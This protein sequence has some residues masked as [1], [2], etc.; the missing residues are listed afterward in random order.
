[1]KSSQH[2]TS[3]PVGPML[4]EISGWHQRLRQLH[5]RLR[6]YFA[7]PEVFE[8]TLLYLQA[9]LSDIPRKNGWQIAEQARQAHPYGMQRLLSRA[10]WDQDG[11]RDVLRRLVKDTLLP[12]V[13]APQDE[14][15][16]PVLVLDESGIPKR[17]RHSAG[18][19]PQYCGRTGRVEN[20]QVGVF[21]SYVTSLGHGLID[22]EL[23]LPEDWCADPVRRQATHIP[24]TLTF[25]TKPELAQRMIECAQAAG[26]PIAW[27]V[28]DTVYGHSPQLRSFLQEQGY[29]YALAVPCTEVVCVQTKTGSILLG[30]VA[31][32][33]QQALHTKDWQRL[34]QSLGT[35]GARLFDWARLPVVQA[36][37]ADGRHWLVVRRC[38]DDPSEL[39]YYLVWAPLDT[40]LPTMVQAIGARWHIEEDLQATKGLGLDQY[41]V[42][43]YLGWYRHITL[44][45]LASAFLV[46]I[47]VQS[48]FTAAAAQAAACTALIPLTPSEARHLLAHL[49]WPAPTSAPLICHWSWWRRTH[50]YWAG[51]YHRRRRQ[52]A[53]SPSGC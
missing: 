21:L 20:C 40:P 10:V 44:V 13:A 35:K 1:M 3:M 25:Q 26:L 16:F 5:E 52:K 15:P 11:V 36:G 29:A 7:R 53:S 8:H 51:Y 4:R 17:G 12:P 37:V 6:P 30:D 48:H 47:T 14:A 41:E 39:A 19:A 9:V 45:L 34:S 42:R 49:F 50:Q 32:L 27:V 43:S 2:T 23:Y 22:R 46:D 24:Q 38:L 18:V 28:A 33:A 31:T